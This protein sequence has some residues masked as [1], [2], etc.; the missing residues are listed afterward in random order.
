VKTVSDGVEFFTAPNLTVPYFSNESAL[1]PFFNLST[2][3]FVGVAKVAQD[4]LS[5]SEI[6][7]D[8]NVSLG[9]TLFYWNTGVP[10]EPAISVDIKNAGIP[11]LGLDAVLGISSSQYCGYANR[12][13][14]YLGRRDEEESYKRN[15]NKYLSETVYASK[16][17]F[18]SLVPNI[19]REDQI[20]KFWIKGGAVSN[21]EGPEGSET[22]KITFGSSK[23]DFLSLSNFNNNE[24]VEF[25]LYSVD[26][27]GQVTRASGPNIK[28]QKHE[29]SSLSA[30]PSGFFEDAVIIKPG[31]LAPDLTFELEKTVDVKSIK[32][33]T[34]EVDENLA[35]DLTGYEIT[36]TGSGFVLSFGGL[37]V[38]GVFGTNSGTYWIQI[39]DS[40]ERLPFYIAGVNVD[41]VE[42][43]PGAPEK[44]VKFE[45]PDGLSA[46]GFGKTIDSIPILLD[47]SNAEITLRYNKKIFKSGAE[48]YGYFAFIKDGN[49]GVNKKILSEDIGFLKEEDD[50]QGRIYEASL[51]KDGA[52][53][54]PCYIPTNI[55]FEFGSTYFSRLS[56]KKALLKFPGPAGGLNISRLNKMVGGGIWSP[57][58]I[59]LTNE[60]LSNKPAG[61][62]TL[63]DSDNS[64]A[65]IRIGSP[66]SETENIKPAFITPPHVLGMVAQIP[67][68]QRAFASSS[69]KIKD[70]LD[71]LR[72]IADSDDIASDDVVGPIV[73]EDSLDRLSIIFAGPNNEKRKGKKYT[74][75]IGSTKISKS[76][77]AGKIVSLSA[78]DNL[79]LVNLKGIK[80]INSVGWTNIVIKKRDKRFNV[81]YDSTVYNVSTVSFL[82]PEDSKDKNCEVFKEAEGQ[83]FVNTADAKYILTKN[84]SG[85]RMCYESANIFPDVNNTG[86]HPIPYYPSLN[87]DKALEEGSCN[88]NY[89]LEGDSTYAFFRNPIKITPDVN[90]TLK[91][92]LTDTDTSDKDDKNGEIV[93]INTFGTVSVPEGLDALTEAYDRAKEKTSD[94]L[95]EAKGQVESYKEELEPSD[96]AGRSEEEI[97]QD[98][99]ETQERIDKYSEADEAAESAL[100]EAETAQAEADAKQ[101]ALDAA[102][103]SGDDAA[104][105]AAQDAADKANAALEGALDAA[106]S[107][108]NAFNDA[109]NFLNNNLPPDFLSSSIMAVN[110][111]LND[112]EDALSP[113]ERASDFYGIK[114]PDT[115]IDANTTI[116]SSK[117][118]LSNPE[119]VRLNIKTKFD[120]VAAIKF[121]SPEIL[122]INFNDEDYLPNN[123]GDIKLNDQQSVLLL[124]TV[125]TSKRTKLEINNIRTDFII[126]EEIGIIKVLEVIIE[127][128]NQYILSGG[129]PCLEIALTNSNEDHIGLSD[130]DNALAIDTADV[131]ERYI[132]GGDRVKSGDIA[133][134]KER[135]VDNPLRFLSV[136]LDEANVPKEFINSFCDLSFHLTAE[137]SLQLR[138]F[139]VL[140]IPIKV[141]LCIIDVICALLHPIRLA[142]AIIRL[143]LCLYDLILL[144]PQLAVPA[145]FI[146]LVLHLLELLLCVIVKI[147][148][149]CNAINEIITALAVAIEEKNY[150]AIVALEETLNE[151]LISL[152]ADLEVLRPIITILGLFLELLELVFA[153]PCQ[154][155]ADEDDPTCIDPSMIAGIILGKVAP[156]GKVEP[157]ALL[158]LAQTYSTLDPADSNFGN[159]PSSGDDDDSERFGSSDI[160]KETRENAGSIVVL[161]NT[162]YAG[163]DLTGLTDS[164]TGEPIQIEAG[165]FFSGDDDDDGNLDNIDYTKLRFIAERASHFEAA[166]G[167]SFTKSTKKFNLFTGPDP[168]LVEFQFNEKGL[169]NPLAFNWF[170]AA[171]FR[172]KNIDLL[173]TMD[174]PPGFVIPDGNSL[175]VNSGQV[176]FTSPVDG[177]SDYVDGSFS[178]FYLEEAGTDGSATYYQPKELVATVAVS[179]AGTD[180]DGQAVFNEV[181][182]TKPFPNFPML[183]MVDDDFNVYFVEQGEGGQGGIR[184]ENIDGVDCITSISAKMI[185]FPSAPK[186]KFSREDLE[187][188]R[189]AE[190]LK[191]K[192]DRGKDIEDGG[193][194]L[195]GSS[196]PETVSETA[197]VKLGQILV[198]EQANANWLSGEFA[199]DGEGS[200]YFN[201]DE[202]FKSKNFNDEFGVYTAQYVKDEFDDGNDVNGVLIDPISDPPFP[203]Y[204]IFDWANG[205]KKERNDFGD[206]IDS[207][208]VFDFPNLYFIDMRHVAQ[209]IEAACGSKP[210]EL[211]L[212][213]DVFTDDGQNDLAD[214]V[215]ETKD[216]V[217]TF[218]NFFLSSSESSTTGLPEGVVPRI[219]AQINLG[220]L[221]ERI[222]VNDVVSLYNSTREC[223]DD[224]VDRVCKYVVNPLNT[225]FKLLNDIDETPLTDYVDPE[226]QDLARLINYDVVDELE[227]DTD[228]QGFPKITGAMEYA[229]GVGDLAVVTVG[230]KAIIRII[231]RDCYDDI[232]SA[233][234]DLTDKIQI[235]ILEDQTGGAELVEPEEGS[236]LYVKDGGEYT[237]AITAT[238]PGAVKI[239]A[240]IC[241]VSVQAVTE[242]ALVP[243]L[244]N[245]VLVDCV[246][247]SGEEAGS[248]EENFAPGALTKVDRVLTIVFTAAPISSNKKDDSSRLAI[249]RAQV[250]GTNLE[251]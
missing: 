186:K 111:L 227:F 106:N 189:N 127:S 164:K 110:D 121:N 115:L 4:R 162:G 188:Y 240:T 250:F 57:A 233:S 190:S 73:A 141:I 13:D 114:I 203:D 249:P 97:N 37:N 120:Q 168:R 45:D 65:A 198:Y 122:R 204:G 3:E 63:S 247:D 19:S 24:D 169:T 38:E 184:V 211:L 125:G 193:I 177:S 236:G 51:K 1:K 163:K 81:S 41:S 159:T 98:I 8:G 48:I 239:K 187:V 232:I 199:P 103:A 46:R 91:L 131:Y 18:M 137:L 143:F 248:V 197:D 58:Y 75:Y 219:R 52:V 77:R 224:K 93:Y 126:K 231:P 35:V 234:L 32:L 157:D 154:I 216:C 49:D 20:P 156:F 138:N 151:H 34:D 64:Y 6:F 161:D 83:S 90:L 213:Q 108:V 146:D 15:D 42:L 27:L 22:V 185:N 36:E 2:E 218:V 235:Q 142:F 129:D 208:K 150:P 30:T 132:S 62:I 43:L 155:G 16:D 171:F 72:G 245:T 167:I 212:D 119:E 152:E 47:G 55:E 39:N 23:D 217:E 166:F 130:F 220:I 113:S 192:S 200:G 158:P 86:L 60:K 56:N 207:I 153:F 221:P 128:K 225:S 40:G 237:A 215:D 173:Q 9:S 104:I 180:E 230:E 11:L 31:V 107:A 61:V 101:Q 228:L 71:S 96:E 226:Q 84:A 12:T 181:E 116:F 53:D 135:L 10:G 144:L 174:A 134:I 202:E 145:M 26:E 100:S 149:I 79:L 196:G 89:S 28:L 214:I 102:K 105:Q 243:S 205:S 5:Y 222:V 17:F 88:D 210:Q 238:E 241:S 170:L 66:P 82:C 176:G 69:K 67:G 179:E 133:A 124:T 74:T 50:E 244:E 25:A 191:P 76:K 242:R 54:V 136:K 99:A 123:F 246:D 87:K 147:L 118:D 112:V 68:E 33:Y 182:V 95:E 139:K 7:G 14:I 70:Y 29:P 209:D 140:L 251:N 21:P 148:S 178:G 92:L 194:S 223:L 85:D 201:G 165:G 195:T 229:S 80:K 59:V 175:V 183:A 206:S 44:K 117:L 78:A 172:K 109:I 160:L 94:A